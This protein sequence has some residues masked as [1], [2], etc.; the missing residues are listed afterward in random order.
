MGIIKTYQ[1][2]CFS[3]SFGTF[4]I[5]FIPFIYHFFGVSELTKWITYFCVILFVFILSY[6]YVS[7]LPVLSSMLANSSS[8]S[9]FVF[10]IFIFILFL[11]FFFF[12]FLFLFLFLYLFI[13]LILFIFIFIFK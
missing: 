5:S 10:F 8:P 1:S 13:Y 2:G 12:F 9:Q 6:G 7:A 3:Q 4:L 11:L